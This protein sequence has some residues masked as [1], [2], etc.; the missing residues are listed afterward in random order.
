MLVIAL[1]AVATS[2]AN[3][4]LQEGASIM[5]DDTLAAGWWD[6]F[7]DEEEVEVEEEPL[8]YTLLC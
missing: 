3:S 1:S 7:W 5:E 6:Q 2:A 8:E 4:T